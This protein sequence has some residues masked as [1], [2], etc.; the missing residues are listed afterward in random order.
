MSS[1]TASAGRNDPWTPNAQNTEDVMWKTNMSA[2]QSQ[3]SRL[4]RMQE[5]RCKVGCAGS[6]E[7]EGV[8]DLSTFYDTCVIDGGSV[9]LSTTT[10]EKTMTTGAEAFVGEYAKALERGDRPIARCS[11]SVTEDDAC[12]VWNAGISKCMASLNQK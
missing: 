7:R 8:T 10:S 9:L 3:E 6:M 2:D 12:D 5:Q 4:K 1:P 11:V